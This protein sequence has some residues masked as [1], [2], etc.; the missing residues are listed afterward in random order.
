MRTEADL[1]KTW[2]NLA[3]MVPEEWLL[4]NWCW[5]H[6][7]SF[8]QGKPVARG[9]ALR[10]KGLNVRS[11]KAC[12]TWTPNQSSSFLMFTLGTCRGRDRWGPTWSHTA[13]RFQPLRLKLSVSAGVCCQHW[14]G[15]NWHVSILQ[16]HHTYYCVSL[17]KSPPIW[18]SVFQIVIIISLPTSS[19]I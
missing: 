17:Y 6:A 16:I 19:H 4:G 12:W 9:Q 14:G 15:A 5:V 18:K 11:S 10:L 7:S 2:L 1:T 3:T 8:Y 13:V